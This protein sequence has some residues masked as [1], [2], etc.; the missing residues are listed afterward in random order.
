MSAV[1]NIEIAHLE[2]RY[3]HSRIRQPRTVARMA[4]SMARFGQLVPVLV[5]QAAAPV[6]IDGYL[7]VEALTRLKLDLVA[8]HLWPGSESDALIHVL[9]GQQGR[10][11]ELFE[12]AAILQELHLG[13][14][15]SRG[16][17][18]RL[19][20]KDKSWVIRR[21]QLLE[22]LDDETIALIRDGV[23]SAWSAQRVLVPVARAT[24]EH[25]KMIAAGLKKHA[26]STRRLGLFF[27]H[28][29][30]SNRK[31]RRHMASDPHLFLK[32][33][34]ARANDQAAKTLEQ[35]PEG[36]WLK[37]IRVVKHILARLVKAAPQVLYRGQH[38]LERRRFLTAYA[39]AAE[40]MQALSQAIERSADDRQSTTP[41]DFNPL[42]SR[43]P[44]PKNQ[45]L[46]EG[47]AQHG[48]RGHQGVQ[49]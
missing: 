35:G 36:Q 41:D 14:R 16:A 46:G 28:Y 32:T 17:I 39:D 24:P 43:L 10:S 2:L 22:T 20:A 37:D 26:L 18:A 3:E 1:E 8:A 11:W 19:L 34:E 45:P 40:K 5:M 15:L 31:T 42:P 38:R 23:I 4:E 30:R 49:G 7:R 25:A 44:N 9:A 48:A 13:H 12:Q 47:L 27:E 29:K 33:L 21:L 6:L